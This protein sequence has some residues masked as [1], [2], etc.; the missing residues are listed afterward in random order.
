MAL[1]GQY[2][3][4]PL[5]ASGG[6]QGHGE[7]PQ[8]ATS[9]SYTELPAS[10]KPPARRRPPPRRADTTEPEA[11][12][13]ARRSW[14]WITAHMAWVGWA[15]VG[16]ALIAAGVVLGASLTSSSNS[17]APANAGPPVV[18]PTLCGSQVKVS[19]KPFICMNRSYGYPDTAFV[20][21]GGDFAPRTRVSATLSEISPP[22]PL[23]IIPTTAPVTLVT[24]QDGTLR[25]PVGRLHTGSLPLG[26]VTVKVTAPGGPDLTTHFIVIPTGVPPP[27]G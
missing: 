17:P 3:R 11:R 6:K 26:M 5:L 10:Y 8:D 14:R 24:G 23:Q 25:I 27:A 19:H 21:Q 15:S 22:P 12:R 18:P 7:E 13:L 20:V 4:N 1:I 16:A 2:Q 9:A